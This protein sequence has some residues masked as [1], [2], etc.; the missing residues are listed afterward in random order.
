V[1]FTER[2]I[3]QDG[4]RIMRIKDLSAKVGERSTSAIF[5]DST[6]EPLKI[7]VTPSIA[8]DQPTTGPLESSYEVTDHILIQIVNTF[9]PSKINPRVQKIKTTVNGRFQ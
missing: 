4:R 9:R 6:L 1:I 7:S 3:E 8:R 5:R 2:V